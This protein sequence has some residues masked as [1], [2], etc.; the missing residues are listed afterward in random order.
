MVNQGPHH[1][2][3]GNDSKHTIEAAALFDRVQM[4]ANHH[5]RPRFC[6]FERSVHGS[7]VIDF[8]RHSQLFAAC[9]EV[10]PHLHIL[11]GQRQPGY[12]IVLRT[13]KIGKGLNRILQS[14]AV[15]E[16]LLKLHGLSL[17]FERWLIQNHCFLY[18]LY[19]S[20]SLSFYIL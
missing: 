6:S 15:H 3:T 14:P 5:R 9:T 2:Q 4:R 10:T 17:R 12:P 11:L 19:L 8:Y 16:Y 7:H 1:F 18:M 13:P 20:V